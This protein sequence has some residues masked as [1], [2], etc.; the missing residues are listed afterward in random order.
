MNR[1]LR[2]L[3]TLLIVLSGF[4]TVT[5]CQVDRKDADSEQ[6]QSDVS[7][8]IE[9]SS[10]SL[11]DNNREPLRSIEPILV[12]TEGQISIRRNGQNPQA[13]VEGLGLQTGDIIIA[14]P[15]GSAEITFG[16]LATLRILPNTRVSL[17]RLSSREAQ[18]IDRD[19]AEI[20]LLAGAILAK[21]KKLSGK[22]EFLVLTPNSAAGVRGTQFLVRYEE[23][24]LRNGIVAR[25]DRTTVAVREGSV[26]VLPKGSLLSHLIDGK[27]ANP[28]ADAVVSAAFTFAPKAGPGQEL[29]IGGHE[30][31]SAVVNDEALQSQ[32]EAAYGAMVQRAEEM[33][34]Q[35]ADFEMV[36][37]PASVLIL[38]DSTIERAFANL[39]Q[40]L[41]ALLLSEQSRDL[42]EVLDRMRE[43]G[44]NDSALPAGLPE[45][46]FGLRSSADNE[47]SGVRDRTYSGIGFTLPL[48]STALSGMISRVGDTVLIVDLKGNLYALDSHGK[49]LWSHPSLATFTAL[50]SSLAV[51]ESQNIRILRADNGTELGTYTFES[52]QALPQVKPVPV[53]N[54]IAIATPRGVTILR[55]ENAEVMAEVAVL[56]GV[57]AP[58]VLA[59]SKLVAISGQGMVVFIDVKKGQITDELSLKV[60]G[61]MTPRVKDNQLFIST[62]EG[63]IIAIDTVTVKVL[64]D[65]QLEQALRA[66]PELDV[67][68][69]YVWLQNKTLLTLSAIDGRVIGN[70]I[71]DVESP[72][73]LSKGRLYW[74]S[75]GPSLVIA[76]GMTGTIV[77][78]SPLPDMVSARP[79]LVDGSLYLGTVSGK[80]IRLDIDKL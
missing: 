23:P 22:D 57:V 34:A 65:I 70:P 31:P 69:L 17:S 71:Q 56:G 24:V 72:P 32:A 52:G 53:P 38:G 80:L 43:P 20:I 5:G 75:S 42:L 64:W 35:G 16:P 50:D 33:Q 67:D 78:R 60:S 19:S 3:V 62:K 25:T 79:L 14:G 63:R 48:S 21:V 73:L 49:T 47:T 55:Q 40:A 51:L 45:R 44:M 18:K 28:L 61:A 27:K 77:K 68:R 12:F 54:G 1:F 29:F 6:T 11:E 30:G 8:M 9:T 36:Q 37:D 58:L 7:D 15:D 39:S 59:D 10:S 76:D 13:G 41:P 4:F 74:G 26:A 2:P 66:E 46:Y